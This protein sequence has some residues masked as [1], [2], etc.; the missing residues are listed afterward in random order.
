LGGGGVEDGGEVPCGGVEGGGG[1]W[2]GTL[3]SDDWGILLLLFGACE[4]VG[5]FTREGCS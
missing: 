3:L 5:I 4:G 1:T 2:V